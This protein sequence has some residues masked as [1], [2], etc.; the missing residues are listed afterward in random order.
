M[1]LRQVGPH[2]EVDRVRRAGA[3]TVDEGGGRAQRAA[4]DVVAV[5]VSVARVVERHAA[6]HRGRDVD[7]AGDGDRPLQVAGAAARGHRPVAE[8][9]GGH[10]D[11]AGQRVARHVTPA[12]PVAA[13][14]L[15]RDPQRVDRDA[16]LEGERD[17]GGERQT[18]WPDAPGAANAARGGVA[19]LGDRDVGGGGQRPGQHRDPDGRRPGAAGGHELSPAVASTR[20]CWGP[21]TGAPTGAGCGGPFWLLLLQPARPSS[22]PER[23]RRAEA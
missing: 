6:R 15:G 8:V 18:L 14:G 3:G 19:D 2:S 9:V 21:P 4:E 11:G 13:A 7:G 16:R 20:T 12:E 1:Q 17:R 5:A 23:M 22:A 10:R